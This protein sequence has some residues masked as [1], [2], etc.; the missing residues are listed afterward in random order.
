MV[1]WRR[2]GRRRREGRRVNEFE[3]GKGEEGVRWGETREKKE[4]WGGGGGGR[5]MGRTV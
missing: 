3:T 4:E 1:G 5:V 2:G